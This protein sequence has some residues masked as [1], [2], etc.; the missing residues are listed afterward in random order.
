MGTIGGNKITIYKSHEKIAK[1]CGRVYVM[2]TIALSV[3]WLD[4]MCSE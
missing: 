3:C 4:E 2:L 1:W